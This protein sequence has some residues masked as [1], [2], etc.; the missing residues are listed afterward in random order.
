[1]ITLAFGNPPSRMYYETRFH[2][3]SKWH[4]PDYSNVGDDRF[5]FEDDDRMGTGAFTS[6][7]LWEEILLAI[8]EF[9][10]GNKKSGIW[11]NGILEVLGVKWI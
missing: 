4:P 2:T 1:M 11:A 3:K 8:I 6:T 7:E 9:Y 5:L 10:H